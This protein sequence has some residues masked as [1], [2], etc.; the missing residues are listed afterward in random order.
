MKLKEI[1]KKALESTLS[2]LFEGRE[3]IDT[4]DLLEQDLTIDDFDMV[5]YDETSFPVFTFKE[6]PG[7]VYSGGHMLKK[8]VTDITEAC[9]DL[10][11]ARDI[12]QKDKD[13]I[14]VNMKLTRTK[15]NKNSFV[16]VTLR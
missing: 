7:R 11:R 14:V 15:K 12:Y 4:E 9:G 6:Y 8:M 5:E 2:D 1:A 3:K 16:Q 13:K 10:D